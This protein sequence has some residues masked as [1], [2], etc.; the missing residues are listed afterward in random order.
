LNPLGRWR[1]EERRLEEQVDVRSEEGKFMKGKRQGE[2]DRA[3]EEREE[4][5]NATALV[6]PFIFY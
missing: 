6:K 5:K 4:G 3:E 2:D 1:L